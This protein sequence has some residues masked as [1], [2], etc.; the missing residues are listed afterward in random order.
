MVLPL[1]PQVDQVELIVRFA[2]QQDP[3]A[4]CLFHL[5]EAEGA[6][7]S[8]QEHQ[9]AENARGARGD[10]RVVVVQAQAEIGV[11][12]RRIERDRELQRV[13]DALAVARRRKIL[14]THSAKQHARAIG[15]AEI[16]PGL[17]PLRFAGDP[18]FGGGDGSV[19]AVEQRRIAAGVFGIDEQPPIVGDC[20]DNG[21][22]GLRCWRTGGFELP[23]AVVE[24]G[25]ENQFVYLG[26]RLR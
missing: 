2:A 19:D 22:P 1:V 20:A 25:I 17:C 14:P 6:I 13:V 26:K 16:E 21:A 5:L 11:A 3:F 9:H 23:L 8:R 7:A 15:P 24:P 4:A 12:E 10:G 18:G